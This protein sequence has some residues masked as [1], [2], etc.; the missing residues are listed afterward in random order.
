MIKVWFSYYFRH[1]HEHKRLFNKQVTLFYQEQEGKEHAAN[2]NEANEA[3]LIEQ[4][5]QQEGQG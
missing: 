5:Q 3:S 1:K 4:Q 2:F